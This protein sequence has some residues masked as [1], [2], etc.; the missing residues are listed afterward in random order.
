M[1]RTRYGFEYTDGRNT[2][3]GSGRE[4]RIAG[5]LIAFCSK[6]DRDEWVDEGCDSYGGREAVT[7]ASLPDGWR[8]DDLRSARDW[9]DEIRGV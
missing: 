5:R 2:T 1:A 9:A 4:L 7:C 6:E 3:T 8:R